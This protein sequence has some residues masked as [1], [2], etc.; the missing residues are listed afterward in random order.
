MVVSGV[1][2]GQGN[3]ST[4]SSPMTPTT[5]STSHFLSVV[6]GAVGSGEPVRDE[7]EPVGVNVLVR[8]PGTQLGGNMAPVTGPMPVQTRT[9]SGPVTETVSLPLGRFAVVLRAIVPTVSAPAPGGTCPGSTVAGKC[10]C[11]RPGAMAIT[12]SGLYSVPGRL[13]G[14]PVDVVLI[15]VGPIGHAPVLS[16]VVP[17]GVDVEGGALG[18]PWTLIGLPCS[19]TIRPDPPPSAKIYDGSYDKTV[20]SIVGCP[21]DVIGTADT[22]ASRLTIFSSLD[23]L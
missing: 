14:A 10:P 20:V 1:S 2:P 21:R 15:T 4:S 5:S 17:P 18:R 3:S 12:P 13:V 9:V 16:E 11:S 8:L 6:A 19:L 7:V 23:F 22:D